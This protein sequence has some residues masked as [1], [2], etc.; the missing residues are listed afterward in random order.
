MLLYFDGFDAYITAQMYQRL[1]S[2]G[3][4][5][6]ATPGRH[7]SAGCLRIGDSNG[8]VQKVFGG[9]ASEVIVGFGVQNSIAVSREMVTLQEGATRHISLRTGTGGEL[10]ATRNGTVLGA[11]AAGTIVVGVWNHIQLRVVIHDTTGVVEVRLN[12]VVVLN[13]TGIDTRNGGTGYVDTVLWGQAGLLGSDNAMLI[14]DFWVV[15]TTGA[16]NNGFLGDCRAQTLLPSGVGNAATWTP[17]VGSNYANVDDASPN[18]DTDYNSSAT[19]GQIDTFAYGDLTPTAGDIKAVQHLLYARK[20]DAGART[21]RP[22]TRIGATDYVGASVN[23][24]DS[25]AYAVDIDEVSPATAVAWTLAE[26]N[27]AEFGIELVA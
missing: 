26:V 2:G 7:G 16:V 27:A 5:T 19:A 13:L 4:A 17:S 8:W 22:V 20:D 6:I 15:D 23:V 18:S 3:A 10:Q 25:Y 24:A 1:T 12:S 9:T 21:V 14:D 11:T